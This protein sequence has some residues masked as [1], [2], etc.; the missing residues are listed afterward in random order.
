M[1]ISL[2]GALCFSSQ[3]IVPAFSRLSPNFDPDNFGPNGVDDFIHHASFESFEGLQK[4]ARIVGGTASLEDRYPYQVALVSDGVQF[5]GGTLISSEWVL[6][7]AHCFGLVTH[8]QIGRYNIDDD[9][10]TFEEI[11]VEREIPHP[12]YDMSTTDYDFMLLKLEMPS[13]YEPVALDDG[14]INLSHGH[15]LAVMGW[16]KTSQSVFGTSSDILLEVEVDYFSRSRCN[17][18][19]S[20]LGN[21]ITDR[22]I[23][24]YRLGKD[25]CQGDSGGPLIIKGANASEDVQ[26]GVVSWGIGCAKLFLPGVYARVSEALDFIDEFVSDRKLPQ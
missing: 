26:V 5:C 15:D 14:S 19:Y 13:T 18:R 7:A 12:L 3:L 8:V 25:S 24:A 4:Q 17:R 11:Q 23:C 22:M 10:E 2:V 1:K 21:E 9:S 6:S 20:L 16:G